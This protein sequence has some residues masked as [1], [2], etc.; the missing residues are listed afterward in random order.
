MA[1]AKEKQVKALE[2]KITYWEGYIAKQRD[3]VN[4]VAD[5]KT[6]VAK[7]DAQRAHWEEYRASNMKKFDVQEQEKLEPLRAEYRQLLG[8]DQ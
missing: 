8:L 2:N 5:T 3:H 4:N 7:T 1:R 6:A